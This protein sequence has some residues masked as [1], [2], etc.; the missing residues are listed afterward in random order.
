MLNGLSFS[1]EFKVAEDTLFFSEALKK[2]GSITDV[3]Q[4]LYFYTV[5][6]QSLSRGSY[7][8]NQFCE[9]KAWDRIVEN[10]CDQSKACRMDCKA[11]RNIRALKGIHLFTKYREE[12]TELK[13]A[14]LSY[15]RKDL[16][17]VLLSSLGIKLKTLLLLYVL[18]NDIIE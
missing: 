2:A 8:W 18:L 5:Q 7:G 12:D 4:Q 16:L 17:E 13:R 15:A 11:S 10:Y 1:S 6:D 3:N 9:I 14:L